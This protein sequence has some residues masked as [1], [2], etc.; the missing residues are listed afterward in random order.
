MTHP[1]ARRSRI[2]LLNT[3]RAQSLSDAPSPNSNQTL[4]F[5][6]LLRS[7]VAGKTGGQYKSLSMVD[8]SELDP[9]PTNGKPDAS[10][11]SRQNDSND[12]P[13]RAQESQGHNDTSASGPVIRERAQRPSDCVVS[14]NSSSRMS[15]PPCALG[16]ACACNRDR[17]VDAERVPA[18][19]LGASLAESRNMLRRALKPTPRS[20]KERFGA[21]STA[22]SCTAS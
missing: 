1:A 22:T 16:S 12:R 18:S 21:I 3:A 17:P 13:G 11:F 8:R 5:P 15:Q 2:I 10:S 9:H 4:K 19:T 20:L 14:P 6:L 7:S